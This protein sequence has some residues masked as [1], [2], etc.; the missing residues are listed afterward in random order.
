M[1]L[2]RFDSPA[3]PMRFGLIGKR[4]SESSVPARRDLM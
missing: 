4:V 3:P 2:C 1:F